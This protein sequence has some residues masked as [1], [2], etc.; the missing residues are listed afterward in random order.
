[1]NRILCCIAV[2]S[3][4]ACNKPP[5]PGNNN[6]DSTNHNTDG[7]PPSCMNFTVTDS[8]LHDPRVGN[9]PVLYSREAY[10]FNKSNKLEK[11]ILYNLTSGRPVVA[12]SD[13]FA[14]ANGN[15]VRS[16]YSLDSNTSAHPYT[17]SEYDYTG[18]TLTASRYYLYSLLLVHSTYITDLLGRISSVTQYADNSTYQFTPTVTYDLSYDANGNLT[19][20]AK[21]N[22]NVYYSFQDYDTHPNPWYQLPFDFAYNIFDYSSQ[23]FSRNN[24]KVKYVA[25][26]GYNN[27]SSYL[28]NYGSDG[29][30]SNFVYTPPNGRPENGPGINEYMQIQYQ[31]K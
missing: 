6:T 9:D 21:P 11:H 29:R 31:C 5:V 14:Y 19:Q 7:E 28:Y 18:H 26:N 8:I 23:V 1:M 20:V 10:I 16:Y 25:A 17:T 12:S 27:L 30:V 4:L 13:S 22:G 3:F 2:L 24:F 15:M